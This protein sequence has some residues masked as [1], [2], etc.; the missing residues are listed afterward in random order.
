[1]MLS[2]D[3]FAAFE[4]VPSFALGLLS[5][6]YLIASVCVYL[7]LISQISTGSRNTSTT[8][9][10]ER[11]FGFPEA[12]LAGVLVIFFLMSIGSTAPDPSLQFNP[13]NLLANL[14][15]TALLVLVIVT[16]LQFRGLDVGALAVFFRIRVFRPFGTGRDLLFLSVPLIRVSE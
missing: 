3:F 9:A 16:L 15:L 7:S 5:V 6:L 8:D 14:L 2:G 10:P 11:T 12:I 1:M 13:R 4:S